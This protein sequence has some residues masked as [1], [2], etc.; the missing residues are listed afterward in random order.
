[1]TSS[2]FD[3]GDVIVVRRC[4]RTELLVGRRKSTVGVVVHD[5][6]QVNRR[7]DRETTA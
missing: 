5:G 1:V 3:E 7:R 6:R 4:V 2:S